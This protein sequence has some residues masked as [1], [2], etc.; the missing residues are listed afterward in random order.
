MEN[1]GCHPKTTQDVLGGSN[2]QHQDWLEENDAVISN[3][4]AEKNSLQRAYIGRPTNAKKATFHQCPRL[5]Q[6][7]LLETQ[8]AWMAPKATESQGYAGRDQ[9]SL[10]SPAKYIALIFSTDGTTLLI[11]KSQILKRWTEQFKSI[12]NHLST[13][14]DAAIDRLTEVE[15]NINLDLPSSL[16]HATTLQLESTRI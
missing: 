14:S 10:L 3:L 11:E 12:L 13:F 6:Q 2:N 1:C 4:L 8:D 5:V 9:S 7:W 15:I 16:C